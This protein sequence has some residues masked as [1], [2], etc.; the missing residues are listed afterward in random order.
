VPQW[1]FILNGTNGRT[2]PVHLSEN[3]VLIWPFK[4]ITGSQVYSTWTGPVYPNCSTIHSLH[5]HSGPIPAQ[6]DIKIFGEEL[7]LTATAEELTQQTWTKD[8]STGCL[9]N[10][11]EDPTEHEDLASNPAYA[12]ILK[13]MQE[14]LE[15]LNKHLFKPDRG[16]DRLES[17]QVALSQGRVFGPFVDANEYYSDS[18]ARSPFEPPL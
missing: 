14:T 5:N 8:C 15:E 13:S 6:Q 11:D 16:T 1:G 7:R 17:C 18:P 4:L 3:A 9:M 10:L 2:G 12:T